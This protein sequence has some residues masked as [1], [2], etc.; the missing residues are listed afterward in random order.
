M[1]DSFVKKYTSEPVGKVA[2]ALAEKNITASQVTL[3]GLGV[4][5]VAA[6]AAGMQAYALGLILMLINRFSDDLDDAV[7]DISGRTPFATYIDVISNVVF[8][9]TVVFMFGLGQT[10]SMGAAFVLFSFMVMTA[11][12]YASIIL[13]MEG[14]K[15]KK[16]GKINFSPNSLVEGTETT[17][18]LIL[19]FL[20]P[21]AFAALSMIFGLL[22]WVT[23]G[24]RI[25]TTYQAL[26]E[27]PEETITE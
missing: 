14:E 17:I 6:F 24:G 20:F 12:Y 2:A 15:P 7:A 27:T 18:Y 3:A 11:T 9:G 16:A 21:S 10:Q 22:C 19:I 23:A 25:Y 13:G 26:K 1:L 8:Y 5:L 4:G